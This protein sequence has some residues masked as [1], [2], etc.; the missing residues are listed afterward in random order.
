VPF[1]GYRSISVP[2]VGEHAAVHVKL[3]SREN[4]RACQE[5]CVEGHTVAHE[6]AGR[7]YDDPR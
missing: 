6:G 1:R 3:V 5:S 7:T 2:A 4:P